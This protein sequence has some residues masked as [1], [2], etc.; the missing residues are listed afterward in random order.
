MPSSLAA[1]RLT[2]PLREEESLLEQTEGE[3][4]K[5]PGWPVVGKGMDR[6]LVVSWWFPVG[7]AIIN[8]PFG[9]GEPTNYRT[10][11]E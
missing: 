6:F 9:K 8:H 1:H 11:D 7:I 2:G 4:Q 5:W 3:L 10:G